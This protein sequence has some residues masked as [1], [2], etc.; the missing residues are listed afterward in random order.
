VITPRTLLFAVLALAVRTIVLLPGLR[1]AGVSGP[2]RKLIAW[3]G[4]RGLSTLLLVLLAVFADVPE[5]EQL[6]AIASLVVLL[7]VALHGGGMALLL[8]RRT[9]PA[10]P[11]TGHVAPRHIAL[12]VADSA[13]S[14][15]DATSA[16]TP[17]RITVQEL[18]DLW[19]DSAEVVVVDVRTD[20]TYRDDERRA[21]G[22][23]RMPPD[24]PVRTARSLRLS[25]H[26]TLVVYCA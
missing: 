2:S 18:R 26:A 1:Y 9:E 17:E 6:F 14:T 5:A 7:S 19:A 8:R 23:V 12:P 15:S 10:P 22:A 4:P 20:R 11:P 24:D 13:V 25:Q 16:A 21:R 3:F